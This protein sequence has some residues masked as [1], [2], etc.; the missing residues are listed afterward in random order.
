MQ[1]KD[2][3]QEEGG[4]SN[5]LKLFMPLNNAFEKYKTTLTSIC[6]FFIF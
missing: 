6:A 2:I 1:S 3:Q 4:N 5:Q